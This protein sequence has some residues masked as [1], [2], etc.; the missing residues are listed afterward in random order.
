MNFP[1]YIAV[2]AEHW[3]GLR[4]MQKSPLHYQ[5]RKQNER[6]DSKTLARGRA[7][8]TAVLEPERFMLDYACYKG[9]IRRGKEW[10]A[11]KAA[12]PNETILTV[13]EY[14][15]AIAIGKAVRAHPVASKI[16][17]TAKVEQSITW[18]DKDTGLKCKSRLDVIGSRLGDLKSSKNID[19]RQF[20][21]IAAKFGYIPQLAMYSDGWLEVTGE[22]PPACI[23]AAEHDPPHDVAVFPLD[24]DQLYMGQEIYKGLLQQ[25]AIC[26]QSG[27]WN[28]RYPDEEPMVLP[29]WM[30]DDDEQELT[31]KVVDEEEEAA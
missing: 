16:L 7:A 17:A 9:K 1:D 26:K 2:E 12:H 13:A 20:A 24:E 18:T 14:Q 19:V 5:Y 22:R 4:E 27:I 28:G 25:V 31:A 10:D 8:H 6:A 30:Y 21:N 23:I 29:A 15:T 3:S 11:F